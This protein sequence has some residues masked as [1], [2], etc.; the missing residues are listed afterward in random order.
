[1]YLDNAY[2]SKEADVFHLLSLTAADT[3]LRN[4][5]FTSLLFMISMTSFPF[6]IC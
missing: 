5:S 3:V 2:S 1:M 4:I 6:G